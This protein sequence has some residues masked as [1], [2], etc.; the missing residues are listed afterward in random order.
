[1]SV[2]TADIHID[3]PPEKVWETIMDP[4][5]FGDWVTIHRNTHCAD[6][7]PPRK[8]MAMEQTLCLRGANFKVKWRLAS[9]DAPRRAEW[10]GKGPMG[11]NA[12]TIYE[13]AGRGGGTDFHYVNEFKAPGGPLG[14]VASKVLVGGVPEREAHASLERLRKLLES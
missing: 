11:S 13:L 7:G 14:A 6:S 9:C 5:R 2:V 12:S 4:Q 3:A 10:V 8:G 1:M